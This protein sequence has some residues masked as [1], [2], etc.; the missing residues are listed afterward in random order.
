[1]TRWLSTSSLLLSILLLLPQ[2]ILYGQDPDS[3]QEV[4]L[5]FRYQNVLNIYVTALYEEEQFYLPVSDLMNALQID[6]TVNL[7]EESVSGRFPEIGTYRLNFRT[8]EALAGDRQLLLDADDFI[9]D[10]LDYYV[11]PE[12]LR[13][14]FDL[15]FSVNFRNLSLSLTAGITLP[16]V[17]QRERERRRERQLRARP[18][19]DREYHPL[20]YDRNHQVFNAG[21]IDYNLTANISE[22]LNSYL[23]NTSLGT[24]LLGGDLQGRI[25]GNWSRESYT[26]RSSNLRWQ[27]GTRESS[28]ITRFTAGQTF[29]T[30]LQPVAFTGVK[31]TNEPIEPRYLFDDY[32]FSGSTTP[33]TEVELYRNNAL[34]DFHRTD[35]SG[36]Y[37]FQVPLTYGTTIY[38]LR[39]FTPTGEMFERESRIQVPFTFLPP[40]EVNYTLNA[41]RL[42]NP[43]AG[44]ADRGMM[45]QGTVGVGLSNRI[46]L[47]AGAEYFEDFHDQLP[48][49]T[50][51]LSSRI[52]T[53]YLVSLEAASEAF[54]RLN[55]SVMYGGGTS[56]N[57]R[58]THFTQQGGLY[59]P[60]RNQATT[61]AN[62]FTPFQIGNTPLFF[63]AT[64]FQDRRETS[65]DITRYRFD[66]NTRI[67]RSA[68]RIGLRDNQTGR[69]QLTTTPSA[70]ITAS[71]RYTIPR[72]QD[73]MRILRGA[74]MRGQVQYLPAAEQVEIAEL[75]VSRRAFQDGRIQL[76][77]GRNFVSDFNYFRLNLNINFDR[78]RTTSNVRVNRGVATT[79]QGIRGSVGLDSEND[80]LMLTNRQQVGRAGL[81][82]RMFVDNNNSGA[83]D[84]GDELLTENALRIERAGGF[85]RNVDGIHYATGL[86]PYRR[87]NLEVNKNVI[88]NPLLV[89]AVDRFSIVTDPN[90]FKSIDIP[91][92]M[93]GVIEGQVLQRRIDELRGLAGVRL[94][95]QQVDVQ[96]GVTPHSE[97]IRTFSDGSFYAYEIPPGNYTLEVDPNQLQFLSAVTIP[98]KLEFTVESRS[99]GDFIDG[100]TLVVI[101]TADLEP[102]TRL[103]EFRQELEEL[104]LP[105]E[106][107]E[108]REQ[109]AG[110]VLAAEEEIAEPVDPG[111]L[112]FAEPVEEVLAE[113]DEEDLR[114]LIAEEETEVV[115][116]ELEEV[117]EAELAE[118]LEV[119][120]AE[121]DEVG[122]K[123]IAAREY[124]LPPYLLSE[125]GQPD[126]LA[127][128]QTVS[129]VDVPDID[130]DL[131]LARMAERIIE[132]DAAFEQDAVIDSEE[133]TEPEQPADP[134]L[135]VRQING[136]VDE[137]LPDRPADFEGEITVLPVDSNCRYSVQIGSYSSLDR[138]L[139]IAGRLETYSAGE[140]NLFYNH[141]NGLYTVRT[142]E[143]SSFSRIVSIA[144]QINSLLPDNNIAL[145]NRCLR[146]VAR[147]QPVE[148]G[149]QIQLG[150]FSD[151]EAAESFAN[152]LQSDYHLETAVTEDEESSLYRVHIGPFKRS[153]AEETSS[154]I[155][156]EEIVDETL[157]VSVPLDYQLQF[158]AFADRTAAESYSE[159][160]NREL[161][162]NT[163][164][165][166]SPEESI[167]RV[168]MGP[169]DHTQALSH[170]RTLTRHRQIDS[171]YLVHLPQGLL[172]DAEPAFRL[173]IATLL[174]EADAL[175]LAN[176]LQ[177]MLELPTTIREDE[178]NRYHVFL[179][180]DLHYWHRMLGIKSKI[181]ELFEGVQ[182]LIHMIEE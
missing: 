123:R 72:S 137:E 150:A 169:F 163:F 101:R 94:L 119:D 100:L 48:T 8:G 155:V 161:D 81:A 87:Y 31:L 82:V 36:A 135:L 33:N 67:G 117:D 32:T 127:I 25:F 80:R 57:L 92:Y 9:V 14:L 181:E 151:V 97:T 3:R 24:E 39:M 86:Q 132:P 162:L 78:V 45:S 160:L 85:I 148:V 102:V 28:L 115:E 103:D 70:R 79:T 40:G 55:A 125:I 165:F 93:S 22:S 112:E 179:D 60:A 12:I 27:Y 34:V 154:W 110:A 138:A 2:E 74:F 73:R 52:F 104:D 66:L 51:T 88:R 111:E 76:S 156:D 109:V 174:S 113:I 143:K 38:N 4:Y 149:Y 153:E 95:L 144:N 177:Y 89:P 105:Y 175:G 47:S 54:Y 126:P 18:D 6:I 56:V 35:E 58:Y 133:L 167:Y 63:R 91:L 43:I 44:V 134:E 77:A 147:L 46:S 64:I 7:A 140:M 106:E 61:Q 158:G 142:V 107:D 129:L 159:S 41:G 173:Q 20:R 96:E 23:F 15:D 136:I 121:I 75:Q 157:L 99:D 21:F 17:E 141:S 62:V 30:G 116:I 182:P 10:E 170:I 166:E 130:A 168:R 145:V 19:F 53:Q 164:I 90:Q 59:N 98:E 16:I 124:P 120:E 71:A 49:I 172:F 1:M 114:E 65:A 146:D 68:I 131:W 118:I 69:L 26:L 108:L 83:Y 128:Q 152:R 42:D 84:E 11:R 178:Q 122:L 171:I 13:E 180:L 37:E 139:R 176:Q 29:S 5:T 50:A